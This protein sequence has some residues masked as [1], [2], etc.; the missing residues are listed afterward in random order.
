MPIFGATLNFIPVLVDR[1][2]ED[3]DVDA[4]L[5]PANETSVGYREIR[6]YPRSERDNCGA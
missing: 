2:C 6:C 3:V 4:Y 1:F 5:G